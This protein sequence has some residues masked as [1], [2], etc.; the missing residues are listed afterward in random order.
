MRSGAVL[1]LVQKL[2]ENIFVEPGHAPGLLSKENRE[3]EINQIRKKF[4]CFCAEREIRC[5]CCMSNKTVCAH[6]SELAGVQ[7]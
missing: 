2:P 5:D 3:A 1:Q 4:L 7:N 6:C